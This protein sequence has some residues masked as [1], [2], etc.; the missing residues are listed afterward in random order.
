MRSESGMCTNKI[1]GE[2]HDIIIILF[3]REKAKRAIRIAK[4]KRFVSSPIVIECVMTLGSTSLWSIK[5]R[6]VLA[7]LFINISL[8]LFHIAAS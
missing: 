2:L 1:R 8:S 3:T 5:R 6:V 7:G 4:K